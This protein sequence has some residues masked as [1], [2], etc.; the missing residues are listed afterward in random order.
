MD[1]AHLK[2][3]YRNRFQDKEQIV[4]EKVWNVLGDF[5]SDLIFKLT[6]KKDFS[7]LDFAAG[8]CEFINN[9]RTAGKKTAIDLNSDISRCANP[10]VDTICASALDVSSLVTEK[11]DVVFVSNFFEHLNSP[12]ELLHCVAQI[13]K[14][15]NR[16]GILI[17]LQPN[18]DLLNTKYW[19]FVD[20]KLP[21]N[22]PRMLEVA[23][24]NDL[25]LKK[26]IVRFL[27]YSTCS[28][29]LKW[30]WL[31][32]LYLFLMPFSGFLFGKQTLFV[33]EMEKGIDAR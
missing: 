29:M 7:I 9:V 11:Y 18:I 31:I 17:V 25:T 10:D 12:E 24:L 13:R 19:N 6:G 1:G 32:K 4:K 27:P 15:L 30:P 2:N 28:K 16:D 22:V 26:L 8:S 5:F 21:V 23:S 14:I 3:I 33:F 20:H